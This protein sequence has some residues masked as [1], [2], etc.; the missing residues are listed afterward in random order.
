MGDTA[1]YPAVT[2]P[3]ALGARVGAS[4]VPSSGAGEMGVGGAGA[5]DHDPLDIQL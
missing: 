4:E 3:P 5:V 1:L 2:R